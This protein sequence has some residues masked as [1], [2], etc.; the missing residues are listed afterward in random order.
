ML[1][2]GAMG[3]ALSCAAPSTTEEVRAD[4]TREPSRLDPIVE[5]E[6]RDRPAP[7]PEVSAPAPAIAA[8]VVKLAQQ[9][10]QGVTEG[11]RPPTQAPLAPAARVPFGTSS[12]STV[13]APGGMRFD[14]NNPNNSLNVG[15]YAQQQRVPDTSEGLRGF[16]TTMPAQSS[17]SVLQPT[18]SSLGLTPWGFR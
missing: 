17:L 7:D 14:N 8:P 5:N 1:I 12:W 2:V 15:N 18:T 16:T 3:T 6:H 10:N 13:G 4:V 11:E 9:S